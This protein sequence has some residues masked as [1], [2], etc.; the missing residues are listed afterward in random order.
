MSKYDFPVLV[1]LK[2]V[3]RPGIRLQF[4]VLEAMLGLSSLG[5]GASAD[6]AGAPFFLLFF[7]FWARTGTVAAAIAIPSSKVLFIIKA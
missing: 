5:L 1:S 3:N 7:F 6:A 4:L 2:R